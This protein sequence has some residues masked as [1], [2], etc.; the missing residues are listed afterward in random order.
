MHGQKVVLHS[1]KDPREVNIKFHRIKAFKKKKTQ[2]E[3]SWIS[4][5]D[6]VAVDFPNCLG[7]SNLGGAYL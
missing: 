5:E 4:Q 1:M 6:V 3:D 7:I 2:L